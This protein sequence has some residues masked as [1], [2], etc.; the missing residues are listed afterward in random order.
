MRIVILSIALFALAAAA[1][2]SA[3]A[4]SG[5]LSLVPSATTIDPGQPVTVSVH[6]NIDATTSSTQ[7]NVTFDPLIL[8]VADVA[9]GSAYQGAIQLVGV[10][11]QT[12]ADAIAEANTTGVLKNAAAFFVPGAGGVAPGD[13]EFLVVSFTGVAGGTGQI[14]LTNSIVTDDVGSLFE[15]TGGTTSVAV[16]GASATPTPTPTPSPTPTPAGQTPTPTAIPTPIP[17]HFDTLSPSPTV[18]FTADFSISPSTMAVRPNTEFSITI[19]QSTGATTQGAQVALTF[20]PT[21]LQVVSLA[22]STAYSKAN[23]VYGV[24]PNTGAAAITEANSTGTLKRIGLVVLPPTTIASGQSDMITVKMKTT[25]KTG[26]SQLALSDMELL[27]E[28]GREIVVHSSGGEISV[29]SSAAALGA[30]GLPSTGGPD[31]GDSW[32]TWTLLAGAAF[33]AFAGA[34]S[35]AGFRTRR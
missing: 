10:A 1:V 12:K 13:A 5:T 26:T 20:D 3:S 32:L 30:S 14:G 33:V 7:T 24:I 4:A 35:F 16:T 15:V 21:L 2:S 25:S 28:D 8:Q 31:G 23:L 19:R 18:P 11:P 34:T 9:L 17:T 22:K 27:N 6:Q 29:S